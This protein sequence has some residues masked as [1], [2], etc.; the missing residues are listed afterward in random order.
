MNRLLLIVVGVGVIAVAAFAAIVI[1]TGGQRPSPL[2]E[3]GRP[4]ELRPDQSTA[5]AVQQ[6]SITSRFAAWSASLEALGLTVEHG[7]VSAEDGAMSVSDLVISGPANWL[8]WRWS[9]GEAQAAGGQDVVFDLTPAGAQTLSIVVGDQTFTFGVE[10]RI[11]DLS[12]REPNGGA[13]VTLSVSLR[14]VSLTGDDGTEPLALQRGEVQLNLV[15]GEDLISR[16]ST[17]A[18]DLGDLTLE[19]LSGGALGNT[20]DRLVADLDFNDPVSGLAVGEALDMWLSGAGGLGVRHLDLE[21]GAL[22]L[23]GLGTLGL[24]GEGRPMGQLQVK[25]RD[26][27]AVLDA[28]HAVRRFDREFLADTYAK[29][30]IASGDAET[31]GGLAFTIEIAAG[32]VVLVGEPYGIENIELGT[33]AR[34]ADFAAA[35]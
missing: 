6:P 25:I 12:A 15:E 9:I 28:L 20:V 32:K 22:Q 14:D 31:E 16:G 3:L 5:E 27:L 23:T 35:R 11:A 8:S 18:V 26:V 1:G 30:L 21:W 13:G 19:S 34:I 33:V 17:A 10:A 24:D 4:V 7:E 2:G 29:L